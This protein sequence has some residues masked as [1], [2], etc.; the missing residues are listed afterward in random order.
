MNTPQQ[1]IEAFLQEKTTIYSEANVQLEPV[2]RKYFGERLL[3]RS[4]DF[5]LR[6]RQ[7]VHEVAQS[8]ASATVITYAHF[9]T[10]DLRA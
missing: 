1:F 5:L 9:K 10:A 2:Y 3:Q 8:S 6:D 4:D 7:V